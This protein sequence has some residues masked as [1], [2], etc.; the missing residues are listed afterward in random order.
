MV[1]RLLLEKVG[2]EPHAPLF[3][4]TDIIDISVFYSG[5]VVM[6]RQESQTL[7]MGSNLI[8]ASLYSVI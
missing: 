4:E 6:A 1:E 8:V 7:I 5:D 3:Q 2:F